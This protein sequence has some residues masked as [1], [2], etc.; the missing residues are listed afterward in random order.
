MGTMRTGEQATILFV[1]RWTEQLRTTFV[2]QRSDVT[3]RTSRRS[4]VVTPLALQ[5]DA[6]NT[7]RDTWVGATLYG[8][9]SMEPGQCDGAAAYQGSRVIERTMS[10]GAP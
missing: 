9:A 8:I 5:E 2:P 7:L 3:M 1:E 10:K 6:A 4:R